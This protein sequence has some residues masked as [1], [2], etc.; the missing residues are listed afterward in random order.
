MIEDREMTTVCLRIVSFGVRRKIQ[1]GVAPARK[2]QIGYGVSI[3][4]QRFTKQA[5]TWEEVQ[6]KKTTE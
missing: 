1:R 5:K 4:A 2:D 3:T 6:R